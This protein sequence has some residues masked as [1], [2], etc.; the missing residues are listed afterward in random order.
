MRDP[1]Q[2][3]FTDRKRLEQTTQGTYLYED[4]E[5]ELEVVVPEIVSDRQ[6][7]VGSVFTNGKDTLEFTTSIEDNETVL[8]S[9]NGGEWEPYT[10]TSAIPVKFHW[11]VLVEVMMA[12]VLG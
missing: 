2:E 4:E 7:G 9:W 12:A 3:M 1:K 6:A 10:T 8:M 5:W 11:A